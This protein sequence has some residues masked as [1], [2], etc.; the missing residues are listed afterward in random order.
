[1]AD[2]W[3]GYA[4]N[5]ENAGFLVKQLNSAKVTVKPIALEWGDI[6]NQKLLKQLSL[7]LLVDGVEI[8]QLF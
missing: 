2:N 6:W 1:M 3:L 4:A 7:L 8:K 5:K